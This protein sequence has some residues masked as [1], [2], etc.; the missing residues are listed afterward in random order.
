MFLRG[1]EKRD[2]EGRFQGVGVLGVGGLRRSL[3]LHLI[4]PPLDLNLDGGV[5]GIGGG[6]KG[7]GQ[8]DDGGGG[9]RILGEEEEEEEEDDDDDEGPQSAL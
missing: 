5:F 4:P 6:E 7:K 3:S 1:G 8:E 2:G 9:G